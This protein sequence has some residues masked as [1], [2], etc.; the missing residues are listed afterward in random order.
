MRYKLLL[1]CALALF[2][3]SCGGGS[4]DAVGGSQNVPAPVGTTS[5]RIEQSIRAQ[6]VPVPPSIDQVR[7]TGSASGI[8]NGVLTVD[9]GGRPFG[10]QTFPVAPVYV[11]ENVP[12]NVDF[13]SLEY[14]DAGVVKGLYYQKVQ[15]V[16]GQTYE[17]KDPAI[18]FRP[19]SLTDFKVK[20]TGYAG[21]TIPAGQTVDVPDISR[22]Q[23]FLNPVLLD[24]SESDLLRRF[25][26][27]KSDNP[28]VATVTNGGVD[29]NS[30]DT[31][32]NISGV[33]IGRTKIRA[34][35]FDI[36]KEIDINV[37]D[38][39]TVGFGQL[40]LNYEYS[41]DVISGDNRQPQRF[42]AFFDLQDPLFPG[43]GVQDFTEV[44]RQVEWYSDSPDILTFDTTPGREGYFHLSGE[45]GVVNVSAYYPQYLLWA[46]SP[47]PIQVE[48]GLIEEL[49]S[50]P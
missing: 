6:A 17:I 5:I 29:F 19:D 1:I 22:S 33:S 42:R 32:G 24:G 28:A 26:V 9:G 38:F 12:V 7:I 27:Y 16:E 15:L 34:V 3:S 23:V 35:F 31:S 48:E 46:L 41:F 10:P 40:V 43:G 2:V 50:A 36:E 8:V 37:Y 44:T 47:Y 14:L 49:N 39:A 45:L 13:L 11:L 20:A 21:T 4:G 18:G 25:T 30:S